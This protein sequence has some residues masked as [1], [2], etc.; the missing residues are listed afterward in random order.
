MASLINFGA[1]LAAA[2]ASVAD[3]AGML[4]KAELERQKEVLADQLATTRE[5]S[6]ENLRQSGAKELQHGAQDFQAGQ[7]DQERQFQGG[8][9]DKQ[10]QAARDLADADRKSREKI[11]GGE[12]GLRREA[13]VPDEARIADWLTKATPEQRAAFH[14]SLVAKTGM[15]LWM[16]DMGGQD[17]GSAAGTKGATSGNQKPPGSPAGKSADTSGGKLNLDALSA[18]P[19]AAQSVVKAMID[20]RIAPPSGMAMTKPYWQGMI[21]L[22][23][24]VD[25][26]FDQTTWGSRS[27]TRKDFTAGQS[28]KAINALN[29]ALGHAGVV[30][31]SFD[32]LGNFGG[33]ATALNGPKNWIDKQLGGSAPTNAQEAVGALASEARKVFAA[34]GGGNL[35]ELE[36]WERNFPVNGSPDQ[37]KGALKQFVNLLD[38]RLE[39][40]AD[41]YNRG[42]GRTEEPVSLLEP[43]ARQVYEQLTG[44]KPDSATGYP[45]GKK[46]DGTAAPSTFPT[47]PT[48]A[49]QELKMRGRSAAG[50]YDAIFGPGAADKVLGNK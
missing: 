12:L 31:D 37:Q 1:G 34:S 13:L 36:N 21:S 24:Q 32:K 29:T 7:N 14:E 5:T 17:G 35:T 19:P 4:S 28:S 47:P 9:S 8:Q 16:T 15:P 45:D 42:M 33:V 23:S 6:L 43:H 44:R 41:T 25:P 2:G 48:K 50:Q 26:D 10:R 40:L 3:T 49:M 46:P 27:A 11:A 38:S 18:V 39:A 20:G 22:A 30:Q